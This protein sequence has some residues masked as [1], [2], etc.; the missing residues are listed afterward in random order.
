MFKRSGFTLIELLVVIAIIA[1]LLAVLIPALDAAKKQVT[2]VTGVLCSSNNRALAQAWHVYQDDNNSKICQGNTYNDQQWLGPPRPMG[3]A[4]IT[5]NIPVSLE[6]EIR[7]YQAGVLWPYLM[8]EKIYHCPGDKRWNVLNRG[9]RSTSIQGMMNGESWGHAA[10]TTPPKGYAQKISEI[11]APGNKYVFIENVDPR[12]WNMGSW[13]MNWSAT[14]PSLIDPIAI[15][16]S[17]RSTFGFADGHAE[18]YTWK[19]DRLRAWA[20]QATDEGSSSFGFSFSP[21]AND[22]DEVDDVMFLNRGYIPGN[23]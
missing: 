2:G 1:I 8:N 22:K 6:D 7:G 10:G 17:E 20:H 23:S 9:F 18:K 11:I 14:T 16:H 13:I 21:N 15:F 4:M 5:S 12:G 3:G 19:S